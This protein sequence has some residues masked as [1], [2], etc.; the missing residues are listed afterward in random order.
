MCVNPTPDVLACLQVKFEI[1]D[2]KSDKI[3]TASLLPKQIRE[4]EERISWLKSQEASF[5]AA[6]EPRKIRES[7]LAVCKELNVLGVEQNAKLEVPCAPLALCCVLQRPLPRRNLACSRTQ[8][9]AVLHSS[10]SLR[11]PSIPL[12]V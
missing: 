7:V 11:P 5:A 8:C 2:E 10:R 4:C 12:H 1:Y 9:G 6:K 3:R